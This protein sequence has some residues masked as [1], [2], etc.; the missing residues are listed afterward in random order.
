MS[1]NAIAVVAVIL[2]SGFAGCAATARA[3]ARPAIVETHAAKAPVA[4]VATAR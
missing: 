1:S 2:V 4:K 3:D